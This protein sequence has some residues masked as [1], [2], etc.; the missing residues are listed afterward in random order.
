MN[1][2]YRE[3]L[4]LITLLFSISLFAHLL[5]CIWHFVGSNSAQTLNTSWLIE[6]G[7]D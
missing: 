2:I 3:Y 1:Q 4:N 7:I 5:A 6:K